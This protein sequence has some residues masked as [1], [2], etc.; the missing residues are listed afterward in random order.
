MRK[1]HT[2]YVV[3]VTMSEVAKG[4]AFK[5]WDHVLKKKKSEKSIAQVHT[6]KPS[7]TS[8]MPNKDVVLRQL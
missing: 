2:L 4:K 1:Q 3:T 7:M 6:V 5:Y 8:Y